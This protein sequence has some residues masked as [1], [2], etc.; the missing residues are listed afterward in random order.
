[1]VNFCPAFSWH[2]VTRTELLEIRHTP[3]TDLIADN[4]Y[5]CGA[6]NES[7][8]MSRQSSILVD[9]FS[10]LHHQCVAWILSG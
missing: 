4:Q 10:S 7:V 1:M 2:A 5:P 6:E 3:G 8:L 9:P